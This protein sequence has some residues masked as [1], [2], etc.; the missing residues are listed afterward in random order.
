[1][2]KK[3][4][5]QN[6]KI[7]LLLFIF[8]FPSFSVAQN[9]FEAVIG[10]VDSEPITTYDLSQKIKIML[11]TMGLSDTIENRDSIRERA[12]EL[13][14]EEKIKLIESKKE[15]VEISDNEVDIFI[16]EIFGFRSDEK[17]QFINFLNNSN[18][19][20]DILFKQIKIELLWKKLVSRKFGSLISPN[21]EAVSKILNDYKKKLGLLEYNFSEIVIY[22]KDKKIEETMSSIKNAENLIKL[23]SSF[24]SVA[25]EFSQSPSSVNSGNVGWVMESQIEDNTLKSLKKMSNGEISEI[26]DTNDSL[27][28]IKLLNQKKIG[29]KNNKEYSIL[30]I[31]SKNPKTEI[32]KIKNDIESCNDNLSEFTS[33]EDIQ[34]DKIESILLQDLSPKIKKVLEN[35]GI[36]Q[37]TKI[38]KQNQKKMFFIIC[39]IKGG[40]LNNIS[41]QQV[42]QK[43]FQ[44]KMGIM[45][46]THL[47]KLKKQSNIILSIN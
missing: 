14:V 36:G 40:E 2:F 44:E 6:I 12:V 15:N 25:S 9:K 24:E 4:Y 42:E 11:N 19:D 5:L 20:Y 27:K 34:I 31:S 7:T 32:L 45:S 21:P 30:N 23:G 37:K 41:K 13:I 10:K 29:E 3:K 1:M 33:N 22:K 39:D 46:R 8:F 26:I 38:I 35:V 28:I 17:K 43:I 16:S 47:N 18:I